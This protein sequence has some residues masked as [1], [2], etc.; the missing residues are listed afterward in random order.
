MTSFLQAA[1]LQ[2]HLIFVLRALRLI[3]FES[4]YQALDVINMEYQAALTAELKKNWGGTI[5][6]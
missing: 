3:E 4:Y 2:T 5:P 6:W 1:T